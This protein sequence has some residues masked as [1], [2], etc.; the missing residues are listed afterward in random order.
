MQ[1][2]TDPKF[3]DAKNRMVSAYGKAFELEHCL[4]EWIGDYPI[5]TG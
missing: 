3:E 2:L 5:D 1:S 4:R